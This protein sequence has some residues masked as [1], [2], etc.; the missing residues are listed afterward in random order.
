MLSESLISHR[1]IE[2]L[3]SSL[4]FAKN[5]KLD[6]IAASLEAA[7]ININSPMKLAIIGKVSSSKSTLVNAILGEADVVGTGQM[8]ETFNVS[9]LKYGPSNTDVV[10]KFKD[11]SCKSVP[12]SE[13]KHWSGQESNT[14]KDRV[15]YLEVTYEHDILKDINIIDTPGLDSAKGTDS[16]NTID[17][18]T[19][20]RPD[21]V[22]M[23]F[24]KGLAQSTLE[25]I[26]EFQGK[27]RDAFNLSPLNA[28][29]LLSKIDYLWKINEADV[30]PK[31]KAETEI[32]Y[33]NI[34]KLFPE[35]KN[36]LYSI[37]PICSMLGLASSIVTEEDINLLRSV[38]NTN[39]D[40]LKEMLHSV[41]D[42]LD[43]FFITEITIDQRE[44]L[45]K[46][47]GLYGISE[48]IRLYK[49]GELTIESFKKHLRFI[50]GYADF[51]KCLYSHFGHRSFLIKT[52]SI[53]GSVMLA[54]DTERR[55][56]VETSHVDIIDSIQESML[57]CLMDIFEYKQL[58]FLSQIYGNEMK[59]TDT[60]AVEEYKRVC[61]EYGSAVVDKLN[62]QGK[63]DLQEM[64]EIAAT[65]F[66]EWNAKYQLE[67][68]RSKDT[69][70]LYRMLSSS[71]D[72]LSKDI[73][74]LY[75]KEI[76]ARKTLKLVEEYIY[77]K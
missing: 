70:E 19:E 76:E 14:L 23:V 74:N 5:E 45:Q 34:Y 10:V 37:L 27:Q 43:D 1:I 58:D 73:R 64:A 22:I 52:Q 7:I 24:T 30:P 39:E 26:K 49:R 8:E 6:I 67:Y 18:L 40:D 55:N 31:H 48:A 2:C 77:G 33:N 66:N 72:I 41:N 32:I 17:F 9:W 53:Y 20:V 35:I 56:A 12:R 50:S 15:K 4:V 21:A 60:S 38:A 63:P 36:S 42:F 57:S 13:W 51:E 54:C 46:K 69:A 44:Y 68:F 3:S 75:E 16:K 65:K 59:L 25:V 47:F 29:G 61:G 71:Y 11:G 62:L 28:I